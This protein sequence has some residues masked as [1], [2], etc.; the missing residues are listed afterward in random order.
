MILRTLLYIIA[1]MLLIGWVLGFFVWHA[2]PLIHML[3]AFAVISVLL[4]I[5]RKDKDDIS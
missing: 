5:S 4:A 3:A 2:G 1:A